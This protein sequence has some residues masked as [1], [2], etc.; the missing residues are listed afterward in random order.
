MN[1]KEFRNIIIEDKVLLKTW[2]EMEEEFKTDESGH[3]FFEEDKFYFPKALRYLSGTIVTIHEKD[4]SDGKFYFTVL[5]EEAERED[6]L[7]DPNYRTWLRP[8]CIKKL[9]KTDEFLCNSKEIQDNFSFDAE[10][11]SFMK[12]RL[13]R[14]ERE[15][16]VLRKTVKYLVDVK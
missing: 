13:E 12:E 3:I 11:F 14:L 7:G 2:E 8:W 6:D 4:Y 16:R 1:W 5:E 10:E 9:I 15:N